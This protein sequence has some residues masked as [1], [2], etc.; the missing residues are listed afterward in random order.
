M[1]EAEQQWLRVKRVIDESPMREQIIQ[2]ARFIGDNEIELYF[3]SADVLVLPYTQIYQSG[4]YSCPIPL[5][6]QS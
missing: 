2:H 6:Y 5:A 1:K 4:M 3:K